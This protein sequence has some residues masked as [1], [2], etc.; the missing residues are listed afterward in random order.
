MIELETSAVLLLLGH[1]PVLPQITESDPLRHLGDQVSAAWKWI[2]ITNTLLGHKGWDVFRAQKLVAL[3]THKVALTPEGMR[4]IGRGQSETHA[5]LDRSFQSEAFQNRVMGSIAKKFPISDCANRV[6]D[7]MHDWVLNALEKD[8]LARYDREVTAAKAAGWAGRRVRDYLR[9]E[10][11]DAHCRA[12]YGAKTQT[13]AIKGD[14]AVLPEHSHVF[15]E[16]DEQGTLLNRE[17]W[18]GD[19]RE[20]RDR[21]DS[22]TDLRRVVAQKH[23]FAV[24]V[25]ATRMVTEQGYRDG[26]VIQEY[27]ED[28]HTATKAK[29]HI[30]AAQNAV[31]SWYYQ[32]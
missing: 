32:V 6:A 17:F 7:H 13:D 19:G 1:I 26:T 12:M 25:L 15:D 29:R 27:L 30:E 16:R 20:L 10:G 22:L 4:E 24:A 2:P 28:G 8:P 23:G 9:T 3:T 18:G 21:L 14:P 11:K 31:R 5:W